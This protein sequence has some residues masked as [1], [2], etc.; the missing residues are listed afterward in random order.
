VKE[1]FAS[2]DEFILN[3]AP[4]YRIF[5]PIVKSETFVALGEVLSNQSTIDKALIDLENRVVDFRAQYNFLN[6]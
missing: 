2:I 3:S 5:N 1:L 4:P 6:K